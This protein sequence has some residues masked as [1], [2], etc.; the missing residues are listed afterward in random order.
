MFFPWSES[1]TYFSDKC[2]MKQAYAMLKRG[3]EEAQKSLRASKKAKTI[4]KQSKSHFPHTTMPACRIS[5]SMTSTMLWKVLKQAAQLH[6]GKIVN[7]AI[8]SCLHAKRLAADMQQFEQR[9]QLE[10]TK[11]AAAPVRGERAKNQPSLED[12]LKKLNSLL[13]N[14]LINKQ[15]YDLKK[16]EILKEF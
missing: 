13:K 8:A 12:R 15:D 1:L 3:K 6:P 11:A 16:A 10:A 9:V 5:R 7:D 2:G 4:R 14:G